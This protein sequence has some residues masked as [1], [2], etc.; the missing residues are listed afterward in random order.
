LYLNTGTWADL[1]DFDLSQLQSDEA[2]KG[3]LSD[4]ENRRVPPSLYFTFARL[5]ELPGG[6]GASVSLE[7]WRDGQ[8]RQVTTPQEVTP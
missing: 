5:T 2:L 7:E 6:R 4:L 3:W 8:I 1:L